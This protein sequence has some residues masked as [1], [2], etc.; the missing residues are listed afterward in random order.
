MRRDWY[1]IFF[2]PCRMTWTRSCFYV[3]RTH[4]GEDVIGADRGGHRGSGLSRRPALEAYPVDTAVPGRAHRRRYV[5]TS[6][7]TSDSPPAP[8]N[9][10]PGHR[11]GL[12]VASDFAPLAW[13]LTRTAERLADS[14][15][16]PILAALR[17][18]TCSVAFSQPAPLRPSARRSSRIGAWPLS[19]S[20]GAGCSVLCSWVVVGRAARPPCHGRRWDAAQ[21]RRHPRGPTRPRPARPGRPGTRPRPPGTARRPPHRP[22]LPR[23]GRLLLRGPP[24]PGSPCLAACASC[25]A[26]VFASSAPASRPSACRAA[27]RACHVS[28]SA[29]SARA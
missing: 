28:A 23:R 29:R 18:A 17:L 12:A 26:A 10:R 22:L 8:A 6:A 14:G 24:G 13:V 1:W 7:P 15:H 20:G 19:F 2:R 3:R 16:R 21:P 25:S 4:R 9:G 5:R 11:R 27:K